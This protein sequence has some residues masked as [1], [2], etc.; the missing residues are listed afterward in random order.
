MEE[1]S[2]VSRLETQGI[3]GEELYKDYTTFAKEFGFFKDSTF[4]K[5]SKSFYCKINELELPI[6][7]KKPHNIT[8]F[9]FNVEEVLKVMKERKWIDRSDQDIVEEPIVDIEGE[10][11]T[12]YFTI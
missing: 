1:G 6:V 5:S 11:F 8:T 12:E 4:Q 2:I 3:T 9:Y 10:D 7:C